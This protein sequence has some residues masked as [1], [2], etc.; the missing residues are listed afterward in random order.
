[1]SELVKTTIRIPK[2]QLDLLKRRAEKSG[3]S[4]SQYICNLLKKKT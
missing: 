1:M 4:Q 2:H 3:V